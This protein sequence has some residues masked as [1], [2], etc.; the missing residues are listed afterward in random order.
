MR[1]GRG[2]FLTSPLGA[3]SLEAVAAAEV[4]DVG[5]GVRQVGAVF[6]ETN[7]AHHRGATLFEFFGS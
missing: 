4:A 1:F 6:P 2:T 7:D 3:E 5:L